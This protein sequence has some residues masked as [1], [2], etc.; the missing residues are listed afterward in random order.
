MFRKVLHILAFI[1]LLSGF[2]FAKDNNFINPQKYTLNNGVK[3]LLQEE[4]SHPIT[5]IQIYLKAG[6]VNENNRNNGVSHVTE[7]LFFRH[8][9]TDTNIPL[10][11]ALEELGGSFNG[12]TTKDYTCY[13]VTLPSK[14]T[15]KALDCMADAYLNFNFSLSDLENEK[16]IVLNEYGS[17]SDNIMGA[18][19]DKLNSMVFGSHPYSMSPIGTGNNI[20]GFK[21]SDIK[22]FVSKNYTPLNT[23]IIIV[24]DFNSYDV[25]DEVETLFKNFKDEQ[26]NNGYQYISS[27]A[28]GQEIVEEK[29]IDN[30]YFALGYKTPGIKDAKEIYALDI[31]T[32]LL[33]QG[34]NCLLINTLVSQK[35]LAEE[36]SA[37]FTT[38]KDPGLFCIAAISKPK[39]Y[40]DLRKEII[41]I[42]NDVKTGNF[43]DE[44]FERARN[45]IIGTYTYTNET[46]EDKA[47]TMGFYDTLGGYEFACTYIEN[48]KKTTKND[49]IREA[50]DL[51]KENAYAIVYKPIYIPE[52][53][54]QKAKIP[55]PFSL[56]NW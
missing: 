37:S 16:K 43:T 47:K 50:N 27:N 8:I 35:K 56:F 1:A 54:P 13:Y 3:V 45:L 20:Q 31:L 40:S 4:H 9:N 32:F 34:D 39:K 26:K 6:S 38:S 17:Y 2:V 51:F 52:E 53:N 36:I 44:E 29:N 48:I 12:E 55:F 42:I 41:K 5:T 18:L 33:G 28:Y 7:H 24:G 30:Y 10:K 49:I 23:T 25:M 11:I 19:I 22:D 21:Q 14:N 15:K 46:N